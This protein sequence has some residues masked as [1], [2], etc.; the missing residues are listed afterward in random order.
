MIKFA[1]DIH[2]GHYGV[3]TSAGVGDA[4]ILHRL[5]LADFYGIPHLILDS[6]GLLLAQAILHH[7]YE[8]KFMTAEV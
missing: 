6:L 3:A 7:L 5:G 1:S 8:L 4:P 2:L